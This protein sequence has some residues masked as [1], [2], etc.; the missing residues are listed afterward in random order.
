MACESHRVRA[1]PLAQ[2][3]IQV[4]RGRDFDDLLVPALHAAVSL[5]EVNDVSLGV[6]QDLHLDVTRVGYGLLQEHR[7][8]AEGRLGFP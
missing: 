5:V 8:V 4:W 2:F 6:G 7:W 1:E 3:R